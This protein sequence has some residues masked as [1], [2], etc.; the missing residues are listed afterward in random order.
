MLKMSTKHVEIFQVLEVGL[1]ACKAYGLDPIPK[2]QQTF[3]SW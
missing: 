1:I 2:H 3:K